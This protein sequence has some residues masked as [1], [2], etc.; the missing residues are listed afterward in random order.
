MLSVPSPIPAA[1]A[2]PRWILVL[3]AAALV[4]LAGPAVTGAAAGTAL[5]DDYW[6]PQ[7]TIATAQDQ[8]PGALAP[9]EATGLPAGPAKGVPSHTT[10]PPGFSLKHIHGGPSYVYIIAG[11]VDIVDGDGSKVTYHAGDFFWEPAGHIH[12]VQTAERAELFILQF[13]P[14]GAEGTIPAQ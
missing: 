13:L 14:P 2:A 3:V 11:S 10:L 6:K 8:P 4:A 5:A 9:F 1:R 12:T 7:A